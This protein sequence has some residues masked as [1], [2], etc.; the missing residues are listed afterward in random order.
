MYVVYSPFRHRVFVGDR[1]NDRV[2]VFRARDFSVETSVA[3]GA[4]VFHIRITRD[5]PTLVLAGG[6]TVGLNPFG[7]DY[8]PITGLG[9]LK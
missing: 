9:V 8:V 3:V 4:G 7:L 5:D 2:V 1:A 6:V